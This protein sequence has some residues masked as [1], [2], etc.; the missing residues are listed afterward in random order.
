MSAVKNQCQC[1]TQNE[2]LQLFLPLLKV[3]HLPSKVAE[4]C[5]PYADTN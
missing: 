1:Q 5:T 4:I 3:D 2:I